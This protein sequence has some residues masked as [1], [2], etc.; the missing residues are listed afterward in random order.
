MKEKIDSLK[1]FTENHRLLIGF[2]FLAVL[3]CY[4]S[5]ALSMNIGIDTEQYIS[6]IYAKPWVIGALGRFGYY[7]SI[8]MLNL[9]HY[10]PYMNGVAFLLIFSLAI[11][12]WCYAFYKISGKNGKIQYVIFAAIFLTNPLWATHF[13]FS[14]QQGAVAFAL[15]LQ[16]VA[17]ILLFDF[18][19]NGER[20]T[21][22][23]NIWEVV[24]SIALALYAVGTYQSFPGLHLSEA[25]ACLMLLFERM[26]KEENSVETHKKFWKKMLAVIVHFLFTYLLYTALCKIMNWGT[27]DYLQLKWGKRP[28]AKILWSIGR[29]FKN[30]LVGG[31]VYAGYALLVSC[32]LFLI[33][34]W[35]ALRSKMNIWLKLDYLLLVAGNFLCMLALNIVIGE[36]P[37]DRA[38]LPVAFGVAFLGMYTLSRIWE[39]VPQSYIRN[40]VIIAAGAAMAVS[41][42]CQLSRSQTLFYTEDVCNAQQFEVGADIVRQI[43]MLGGNNQS[44]VVFTGKWSAPL[45]PSCRKQKPIGSSSFEWGYKKKKPAGATRRAGLYLNAAFGMAYHIVED[46]DVQKQAVEF[47]REMPCYP[48]TGYVEKMG[49]VF[50]IKL[51]VF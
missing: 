28:V 11:L 14:L 46:T 38:R 39:A 33:L 12:A 42:A 47:S 31:D 5:H 43:E 29:D 2:T 44:T 51:G 21:K 40:G 25:A 8:M 17:F 1:S 4:G 13:Y 48:Q 24:L 19:I 20:N 3:V 27:S 26:L 50:V 23:K 35:K 36:I 15:L 30:I 18:L 7:Y 37:A 45:N 6:G 41:V 22:I 49:D 10:N 34:V 32:I 9:G 16:A